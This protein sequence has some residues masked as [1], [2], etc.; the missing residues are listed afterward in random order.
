MNNLPDIDVIENII[1]KC[2][3][4]LTIA[5]E[6]L[7]LNHYDDAVS[8]AYYAVFH[9]MTAVLF[10]NKLTFSSHKE[11]IGAFNKEFIRTGKFPKNFSEK[12]KKLF[13]RRQIGDYDIKK[14]I[15][16]E[17]SEESVKDAG[18]IILKCKEYLA[19]IYAVK[20]D[21]WDNKEEDE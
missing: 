3:E 17:N 2:N 1:F 6:L 13:E 4:K 14:I 16:K 10:V 7:T 12:I 15:S 11:I 9:I 8:R 19:N 18:E 21:Y 20:P 5:R